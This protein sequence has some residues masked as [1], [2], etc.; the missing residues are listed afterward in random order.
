M[1]HDANEVQRAYTFGIPSNFPGIHRDMV[2]TAASTI[3]WQNPTQE[4]QLSTS[5][6]EETE[7]AVHRGLLLRANFLSPDS[8]LADI[9]RSSKA[10][11]CESS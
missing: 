7:T 4:M 10:L 9:L 6:R 5:R 1:Y 8:I 3:D 2:Q 11:R